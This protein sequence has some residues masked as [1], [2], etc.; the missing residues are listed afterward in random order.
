[1]GVLALVLIAGTIGYT[2]LGLGP[3]DALYQTV[4]TVSTVGYREVGE[5]GER[6][7][8]FTLFLILFGTGTSLYTLRCAVRDHVRGAVR[9]PVQEATHA[10]KDQPA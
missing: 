9:R 7:Q 1:M 5:V 8:V 10:T 6:Y 4:I 3:L 2:A